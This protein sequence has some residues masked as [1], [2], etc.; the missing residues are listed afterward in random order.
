MKKKI[1]ALMVGAL[2]ATTILAGCAS[3]DVTEEVSVSAESEDEVITAEEMLS[4]T[5]YDITEYVTLPDDY[6]NLTVELTSNY[7]VTQEEIED[8]VND[9]IVSYYPLY[10]QT[11]KTTVEDGDIVD[12]DYVGTLDGEE[13]DGGSGEDYK[14]TIG[15][16]TFIDG[17]EDGLIGQEV[18]TTVDLDLTFPDD[19]SSEDLAGQDVVFTVTINGIMDETMIDYDDLTDEYV[20]ENFGT[21]GMTTVDDLLADV[22][23]TLE[24]SNESEEQTEIQQNVLDQLMAGSTITYPESL[25]EERQESVDEYLEEI[26]EAA[27]ENDMTYDDYVAAYSGY[28]DVES[29]EEYIQTTSEESLDEELILEAVVADQDISITR[30]EFESFVDTFIAYYGFEDAESFYDY[31]GGELYTMLSYAENRALTDVIDAATIV[32]P[33]GTTESGEEV[34]EQVEEAE[35]KEAE[36]IE[37]EEETAEENAQA[38][39]EAE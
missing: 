28:P 13:F 27:E 1:A 33:E 37:S 36:D 23:D 24:S 35:E 31:Y 3:E 5:D 4:S 16:G 14:L 32:M 8:Y 34:E 19:Y 26:K 30:S 25:Q 2:A 7:E 20:E 22:Q 12:I 29:F 39:E 11:D 9:Y 15:S 18:G 17:F 6:M 21:Y 38:A 10:V